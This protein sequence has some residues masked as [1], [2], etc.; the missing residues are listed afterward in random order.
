MSPDEDVVLSRMQNIC[1]KPVQFVGEVVTCVVCF[2]V[3]PDCVLFYL[4]RIPRFGCCLRLVILIV[5][6]WVLRLLQMP[7]DL[8]IV[9]YI[10]SCPFSCGMLPCIFMMF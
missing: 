5:L 10:F 1:M 4:C 3:A 7:S 9:T 2:I 8:L 6:F